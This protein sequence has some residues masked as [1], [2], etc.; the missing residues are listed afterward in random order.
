MTALIGYLLAGGVAGTIAVAS[1]L[2]VFRNLRWARI[3]GSQPDPM[4]PA[5]GLLFF[6]ALAGWI[7]AWVLAG[8]E[9]L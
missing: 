4:L 7:L 1:A 8:G 3:H 2:V 6:M 9:L 5:V